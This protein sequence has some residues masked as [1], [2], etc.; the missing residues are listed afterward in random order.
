MPRPYMN[1][2]RPLP[3]IQ[4]RIVQAIFHRTLYRR[5]HVDLSP[6][7]FHYFTFIDQ[8]FIFTT[9]FHRP[10]ITISIIYPYLKC[11]GVCVSVCSL[12][13]L[14]FVAQREVSGI[15]GKRSWVR[16]PPQSNIYAF[17]FYCVY[18]SRRLRQATW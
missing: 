13:H 7:H 16:S 6:P 4:L 8:E 18:D 9:S 5:I 3:K 10:S 17:L 2:F 11:Y 12:I 14:D 15:A 1:T